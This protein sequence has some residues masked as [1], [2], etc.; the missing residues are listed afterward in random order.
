MADTPEG[1]AALQQNLIRLLRF[2]KCKCSA[3]HPGRNNHMH[4]YRL[5]ADLLERTSVE[6][7]QGVLVD[8]RLSM[9]QQCVLVAKK[10]NGILG[11][12]K[13]SMASRLREMILPLY[14]AQVRPHLHPVLGS[15]VQKSQGTMGWS[16]AEG[17]KDDEGPGTP[18]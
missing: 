3:L 10:A 13:K 15:S 9:S 1:C 16:P 2:N 7:G 14:S 6:K 11:C 17:N 12:I 5:G 4:Q 18:L 8:N